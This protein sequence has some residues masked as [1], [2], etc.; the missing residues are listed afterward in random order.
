MTA[1]TASQ[2]KKRTNKASPGLG[3]P[4]NGIGDRLEALE[5]M[6]DVHMAS[7]VPRCRTHGAAVWT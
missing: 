6:D 3:G 2:L 1:L 4:G 7:S 5:A